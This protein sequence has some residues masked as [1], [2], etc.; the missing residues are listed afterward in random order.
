MY[1][2]IWKDVVEYEGLYEISNLGNFRRHSSIT[3]N[4]ARSTHI[5]RLGYAYVCLSKHGKSKNKTVH[6]LVAKAFFEDFNYGDHINHIDGNKLNNCLTNLEKTT[7]SANNQHAH[8]TG[9]RTKPGSSKYHYVHIVRERYKDRYYTYY[10][11][12][13]KMQGKIV[14]NKQF[15]NELEAAHAVDAYLISIG[16]TTK[17][18]NFIQP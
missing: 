12:K 7:I 8:T 9:L 16:D 3:S 1:R 17:K 2:E 4:T 5:N 18:R 14:F 15:T 10:Q 11:A 13:I 6:Q